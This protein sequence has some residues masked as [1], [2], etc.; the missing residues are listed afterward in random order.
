MKMLHMASEVH[1]IILC[2]Y[3]TA[4]DQSVSNAWSP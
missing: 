3:L 4:I 2:F 1:I